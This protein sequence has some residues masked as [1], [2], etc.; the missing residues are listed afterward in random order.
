MN[1]QRERTSRIAGA[2]PASIDA[3]NSVGVHTGQ[4]LTT[5]P[6]QDSIAQLA[7]M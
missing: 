1:S 4:R 6:D 5:A 3:I 2:S 7:R